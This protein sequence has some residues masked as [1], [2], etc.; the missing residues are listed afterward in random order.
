MEGWSAHYVGG[1][2]CP[3]CGERESPVCGGGGFC[4]VGGGGCPLCGGRGYPLCWVRGAHYV[5][6]E[7][8]VMWGR[9]VPIMWG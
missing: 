7:V 3:L 9:G 2:G 6:E 5:G 8:P 4:Y 1:G